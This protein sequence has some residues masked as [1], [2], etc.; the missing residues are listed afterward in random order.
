MAYDIA[1]LPELSREVLLALHRY[2][3]QYEAESGKAT[4]NMGFSDYEGADI[5]ADLGKSPQAVGGAVAHLMAEGL[6]W[7]DDEGVNGRPY[8]FLHLTEEGFLTAGC[9]AEEDE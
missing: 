4:R 2:L 8:H 6:V 9:P 5:A 1:T 3:H 7:I